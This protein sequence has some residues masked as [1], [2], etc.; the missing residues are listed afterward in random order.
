MIFVEESG[1]EKQL[2][3][4]SWLSK[5]KNAELV[6]WLYPESV[7]NSIMGLPIHN[8][9]AIDADPVTTYQEGVTAKCTARLPLTSG[10][11]DIIYKE[12]DLITNNCDS[13]CVYLLEEREWQA[14]T[15][16]HEGMALVKDSTLLDE[17]ISLGF[18]AS[19]QA[20]NWW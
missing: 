7:L 16:G 2:N 12:R 14:C 17:R 6:I 3:V 11:I 4:I 20:P 19:L 5:S 18:N 9:G 15:I 1:F 8:S 13:L 10:L